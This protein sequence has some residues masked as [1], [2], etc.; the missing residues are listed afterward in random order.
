MNQSFLSKAAQTATKRLTEIMIKPPGVPSHAEVV[1]RWVATL[2]PMGVASLPELASLAGDRGVAWEVREAACLLLG[3]LEPRRARPAAIAALGDPHPRVRAAAVTALMTLRGRPALPPL[4]E[5]AR[6]DRDED[7]RRAA[8]SALFPY[9][10]AGSRGARR[11]LLEILGDRSNPPRVRAE[12]AQQFGW[13]LWRRYFGLLKH[14]GVLVEEALPIIV[15]NLEDPVPE[16]RYWAAQ[17]LGR[18]WHDTANRSESQEIVAALR[19]LAEEDDTI[20]PPYGSTREKAL[21]AIA[22]VLGLGP[23]L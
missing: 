21:A 7:V 9:A 13:N 5:T 14:L 3:W 18:G 4:I 2:G 6:A 19:K 8:A 22:S 10:V 20:L 23:S 16:V 15:R 12:V 17:A 1:G 11:T